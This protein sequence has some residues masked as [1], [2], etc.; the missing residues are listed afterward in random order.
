VQ[1]I[2]VGGSVFCDLPRSVPG[3]FR[4]RGGL[5]ESKHLSRKSVAHQVTTI[6]PR[7]SSRYSVPP[8]GKCTC[9]SKYVLA[10]KWVASWR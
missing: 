10:G 8:N 9:R 3:Q 2:V 6:Y 4:D 1:E 7:A 5:N